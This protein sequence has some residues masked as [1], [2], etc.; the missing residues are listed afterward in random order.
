MKLQKKPKLGDTVCDLQSRKIKGVVIG[1]K[2]KDTNTK[3]VKEPKGRGIAIVM[4]TENNHD[5]T[6]AIRF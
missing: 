2:I 5:T 6:K 1:D 4:L 3:A